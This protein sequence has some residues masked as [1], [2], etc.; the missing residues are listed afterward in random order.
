MK[1]LPSYLTLFVRLI[2]TLTG[3]ITVIAYPVYFGWEESYSRYYSYSPLMFTILFSTLA[4]GLLIHSNKEWRFPAIFL[5][6]LSVFNMYDYPILHYGSAIF[7]FITSTYAMW[8]DKRVNGFGKISLIG[9]ILI[10]MGLMAFEV[11]QILI[12]LL[13]HLIYILKLFI[14]KL[15]K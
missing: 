1:S 5:I 9:Y 7:F 12:L 3:L 14:L 6:V 10:C 15:N 4:I 11:F 2:L 13:F 8:N